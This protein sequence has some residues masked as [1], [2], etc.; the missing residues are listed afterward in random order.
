MIKSFGNGEKGSV[1]GRNLKIFSKETQ[2][3]A[4]EK[5]RKK[6]IVGNET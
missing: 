1:H 6:K 3:T 4:T 2:T 5:E